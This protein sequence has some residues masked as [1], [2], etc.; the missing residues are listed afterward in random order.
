MGAKL[1]SGTRLVKANVAIVAN[2]QQLQIHAAQMLDDFIIVGALGSSIHVGAGRHMDGFGADVDQVKQV[3]V[4]EGPV[5]FGMLAGQTAVFVQVDGVYFRKIKV[6]L[7][8]P[9]NQ[10]FVGANGGA[11]GCQAQH[12]VGLHDDLCRDD[13]GRFAG[14]II[15]IFCT[16]NFHGE[17]LLILFLCADSH[18]L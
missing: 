16:N 15:I 3:A 13:I 17:H 11:A 10:L 14:H 8:V 5:A 2:A 9:F 7:V 1:K 4:H 6:A 18:Y 12:A